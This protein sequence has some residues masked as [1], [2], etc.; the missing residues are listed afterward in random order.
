M[1]ARGRVTIP[2]GITTSVAGP[3]NEIRRGLGLGWAKR[4]YNLPVY[5]FDFTQGTFM[6]KL[7][8]S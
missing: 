5:P 3:T 6:N 2:I 8:A 7:M 4:E 1:K